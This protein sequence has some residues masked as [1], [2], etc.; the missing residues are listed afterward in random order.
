MA[1]KVGNTAAGTSLVYV[2]QKSLNDLQRVA[3]AL[4][5]SENKKQ[6]QADLNKAIRAAASPL[7]RDLQGAARGIK[8]QGQGRGYSRYGRRNAKLT[9]T[10]KIRKGT[11]AGLRDTI[12]KNIQTDINKSANAAG[13]RII[14]ARRTPDDV[15]NLARKMNKG[16]WRHP[17]FGNRK[18]WYTSTVSDPGWWDDTAK[19]GLPKAQQ[20]VRR[21]LDAYTRRLASQINKAS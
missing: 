11:N 6:L 16:Q 15:A 2:D 4:N 19:A 17:L 14:L 13:V 3:K 18:R 1:G 20:N 9:K 12:A 10:G 5:S 8:V 21:V 7:V